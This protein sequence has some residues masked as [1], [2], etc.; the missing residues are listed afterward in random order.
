LDSHQMRTTVYEANRKENLAWSWLG[1]AACRSQI[2]QFGNLNLISHK[3][4]T[5]NSE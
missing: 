4:I 3:F 5:H 2:H 1:L